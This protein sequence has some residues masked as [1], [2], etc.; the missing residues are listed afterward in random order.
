MFAVFAVDCALLAAVSS[1][2]PLSLLKSDKSIEPAFDIVILPLTLRLLPSH[3]NLSFKLNLPVLSTKKAVLVLLCVP[4]PINNLL[5]SIFMP[6][7]EPLVACIR[8]D[9]NTFSLAKPKPGLFGRE[10]L[11]PID[12]PTN[13]LRSPSTSLLSIS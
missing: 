5:D 3:T 8:P 13:P 1:V 11:L 4:V 2:N 12:E 10:T 6:P 7:I 9:K